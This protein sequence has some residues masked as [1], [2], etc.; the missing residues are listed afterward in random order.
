MRNLLFALCA[1]LAV[2]CQAGEAP[3]QIAAVL[4][5][6]GDGAYYGKPIL[7][8]VLLAVDA[9][10]HSADPATLIGIQSFDD[11]S[12]PAYAHTLADQVCATQAIAV[13]GPALT[14]AALSAGPAYAKCGLVAIA[15]TA[16]GDD[17]PKAA[18]TFQPV[19]N[20]SSMGTALA[21]YLK[22]VLH[23]DR[24]IIL[25]RRDGYGIPVAQGVESAAA[26]LSVATA[27]YAFTNAAERD[28]AVQ[29]AARDP[30]H[31]PI[32]LGMLNADAVPILL[33][34]RRAGVFS[35]VLAPSSLGGDDFV[36]QFSTEPEEQQKRGFFTDN[37]YAAS[38]MLF[39]SAN[40]DVLEFAQRFRERYAREPSWPAVQGYDSAQLAILAARRAGADPGATGGRLAERRA[41]AFK[42]LSALDS[43]HALRGV[44]GPL[45]FTADRRRDQPVRLGL[46]RDGRFD[47]APIQLVP[48]N[49][50][51]PEEITSGEVFEALPG[52]F[53]RRQRVVYTGVFVNEVPRVDLQKSTFIIDFYL[54]MRFVENAGPIGFEPSDIRFAG[55]SGGSFNRASP[56]EQRLMADGTTYRLWHVE[57]EVRNEFD[58]RRFPFDSQILRLSFYNS[59]ADAERVVYVLDRGSLLSGG[60]QTL[61]PTADDASGVGASGSVVSSTAFRLLTQWTP[62]WASE[63]RENLVTDSPLGYPQAPG[64]ARGRELS[65]FVVDLDLQRRALATASKNLLPL[66]I[67][68]II[69]FASL[70]FPHGL[71]KEKVTVAITAALSGAVLLTSINTQLGNLGYTILAEY[72]FYVFF[73]LSLLCILSVLSAERLRVA[74]APAR[75][76]R[77]E[78]WTRAGFV[79]TVV[80]VL[81]GAGWV[82]RSLAP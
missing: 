37:V 14:V 75:A 4:S 66:I 1:L 46:F 59:R 10:N 18:T 80:A 2:A 60:R 34:L 33:A 50:P 3:L 51:A 76:L 70:Y 57:G 20:G 44:T 47:S 61:G 69:M 32:V 78:R 53:V 52:K 81:V 9:A 49:N 42:T 82:V 22:R 77:I 16:H 72:V 29:A 45:W 68:T 54:W 8:G 31:P 36:D 67:M 13:I 79:L 5:L 40:A 6:T 21:V 56:S 25:F 26:R 43:N 11:R 64:T 7:D 71:V 19:F 17:V 15:A 41:T 48:V 58:L 62:V 73:G 39:D 24:V 38:P 63:R 35:P 12:D 28:A 27:E 74:G 30:G 65:G 55:L 23:G